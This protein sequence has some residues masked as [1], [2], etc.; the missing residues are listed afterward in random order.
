MRIKDELFSTT[1]FYLACFL[2]A[3]DIK[4]IKAIWL[5]NKVVFSFRNKGNMEEIITSFYSDNEMVSA[6]KF[7][8]A[9]RDLKALTH[10][11]K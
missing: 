4:L 11:L 6:N 7:I 8:N 1:D 5:G 3:L 2:K 10:N 9:I